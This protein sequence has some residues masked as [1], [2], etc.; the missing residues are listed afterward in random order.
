MDRWR[1]VLRVSINSNKDVFFKVAAS[2][3]FSPSSKALS[4]PFVNAVFFNGDRVQDT[5]NPVI[6][7]LSDVQN[8]AD[9]IVSKLGSYVNAWVVEASTF[10]GP[11]AVYKDFVPTVNSRG[12]PRSYH[13]VGFPASTS[14]LLLLF[15]CLEEVRCMISR[16]PEPS[17]TDKHFDASRSGT[18]FP[19]TVVL[20][21]SKG[22][23][24]VNQLLTELAH[25]KA[26]PPEKT[27]VQTK[28]QRMPDFL[29]ITEEGHIFPSS[30][31]AFLDSISEIHYVDVGLNCPGAYLTEKSVIKK[32]AE[33]LSHCS[34]GLRLVLH[35]TPRQ[36]SDKNRRWI[37]DEKNTL[38]Q[39]LEEEA[40]ASGGKLQV[41]ERFYFADRHPN[42]PMHFEII[43]K[44]NLS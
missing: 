14:T 30:E 1:G 39:L 23:T 21:F 11:F 32:I 19:N 7:K 15:K 5:G 29:K 31:H 25:A 12:E 10:N 36:W 18:N 41:C 22:G 44:M 17:P 40:C 4:V 27:T 3:C 35:G 38:L 8:I 28:N 34:K 37:L 6:E 2:L 16:K 26:Q 9:I 43:E 24:V 13:P 42:L 20:G 33:R